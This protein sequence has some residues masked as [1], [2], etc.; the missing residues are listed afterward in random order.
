MHRLIEDLRTTSLDYVT[1]P[2]LYD[3]TLGGDNSWIVVREFKDKTKRVHSVSD[4]S[5]I[6]KIIDKEK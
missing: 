5:E 4:S 2:N 3:I 6:L 1:T